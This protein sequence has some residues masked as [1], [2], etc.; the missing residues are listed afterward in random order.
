MSKEERSRQAEK[1]REGEK[2]RALTLLP[3]P[4]VPS[5]ERGWVGGEGLGKEEEE[6]VAEDV[7]EVA[8]RG[9]KAGDVDAG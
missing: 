1:G 3:W 7:V 8:E 5:G 4:Q 9:P 6:D 2:T